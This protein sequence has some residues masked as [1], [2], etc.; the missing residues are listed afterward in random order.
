MGVTASMSTRILNNDRLWG[1]IACH[2]KTAKQCSFQLCSIFE[3]L[4]NI[5][6]ARMHSL[7]SKEKHDADTNTRDLYSRI[8]E[9]V[10]ESGDLRKG[11]LEGDSN[12]LQLFK[13]QGAL[14]VKDGRHTTSGAVPAQADLD[15]LLLW[16]HTRRLANTWHTDNLSGEFDHASPYMETASGMLAIPFHPEQEEY[17]LLFRPEVKKVIDWGGDPG[18]RIIYEK[19]GLNYHPRH[20]FK[21][22]RQI[23]S[24]TSLPW[25]EE[26]I[27][28]GDTLRSFLY[29][30]TSKQI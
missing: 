8:I 18:G 13:A 15:E 3:L 1:L 21:L 19:D 7:Q 20:S 28:A 30:Y 25:Q 26:E 12:V 27:A 14:L 11:L 10:Y 4:S 24:G 22:W 5:I 6:S 2:H 16:I 23:V 17:L 29:E 9:H